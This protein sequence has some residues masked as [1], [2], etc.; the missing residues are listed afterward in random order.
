MIAARDNTMT[1]LTMINACLAGKI[2]KQMAWKMF[3]I[4]AIPKNSLEANRL[5]SSQAAWLAIDRLVRY[6]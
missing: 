3:R 2:K 1:I 6:P 4:I 5:A